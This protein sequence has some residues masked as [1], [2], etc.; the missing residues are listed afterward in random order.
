LPIDEGADLSTS[1]DRLQRC[2]LIGPKSEYFERLKPSS[3][4]RSPLAP[5][6]G[7]RPL[8]RLLQGRGYAYVN[9]T[10]L[11]SIDLQKRT[12]VSPRDREGQKVYFERINIPGNSKTP[13][14]SSAAR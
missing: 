1:Q 10:P 6:S 11:T 14:R 2:D 5:W 3:T 9:I 12:V 4:R 8:E 13:T 7:H